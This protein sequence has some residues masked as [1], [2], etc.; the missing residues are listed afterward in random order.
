MILLASVSILMTLVLSPTGIAPLVGTR[1]SPIP[2]FLLAGFSFCS[3]ERFLTCSF[4]P[5]KFS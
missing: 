1:V 2:K 4:D 3:N 5:N